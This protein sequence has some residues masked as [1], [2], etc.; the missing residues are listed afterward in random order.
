M[1]KISKRKLEQQAAALRLIHDI[2]S[3]FDITT[4][5]QGGRNTGAIG[6]AGCRILDKLALKR[7]AFARPV[8][9]RRDEL[10]EET[11]MTEGT[12]ARAMKRLIEQGFLTVS[13]PRTA[14][15]AILHL[16]SHA[17]VAHEHRQQEWAHEYGGGTDRI[18][19]AEALALLDEPEFEGYAEHDRQDG[20]AAVAEWYA[21]RQKAVNASR[22]GDAAG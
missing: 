19:L 9:F 6:S 17:I 15:M 5:G 8:P 16:P 7:G 3:D 21:D 22:N 1:S 12:V 11:G 10:Y 2:A 20:E 18:D 4:K 14:P 13:G